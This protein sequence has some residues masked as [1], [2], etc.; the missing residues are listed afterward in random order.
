MRALLALALLVVLAAPARAQDGLVLNFRDAEIR[1]VIDLVARSTGQRFIFDSEIRGRVTIILEDEVSRDEALE[2]LNAA[3]LMVGYATLPGPD[4]SWKIQS[5]EAAKGAA[6]WLYGPASSESSRLVTTLVRLESADPT[7]LAQILG[8]DTRAAIVLP[9]PATNGLIIAASEDRLARMLDLVRALDQASATELAV[10]PLRYSEAQA[11]ADQL[12]VVFKAGDSPDVPWRVIVEERTN[13]LIVQ[14]ARERVDDVRAF[15]ALVDVPSRAPSGYH[16]VRIVNADAETVATH[17]QGLE[18]GAA[19][20]TGAAAAGQP[21]RAIDVVADVPT[22]SLI[23]RA[24]AGL[25]GEIAAVIAELDRI[26]PRVGIEAH[27]WEVTTARELE[28]GF[29][30]LIPLKVGDEPDDT[31]AFATIGDTSGL[32]GAPQTTPFLAR[33]TR[34]PL[35]IPVLGPD[36]ETID[37]IVPEGAA[38]LIASDGNVRMRTLTSPYL[39]AASGE[40]QSIFAGDQVPIPVTT[41]VGATAPDGTTTDPE[42]DNPFVTD[43]SIERQDV[44][45]ELRVK[46]LA[47]SGDIVTLELHISVTSVAPSVT[48]LG[49]NAAQSELQG[50]TIREFTVDANVRLTAGAVVVVA[51]APL[52]TTARGETGVPFF[53]DIPILGWFFKSTRDIERTRRLVAAVQVNMIHTAD[54]QRAE[55]I[56]RRLALE[57]HFARTNPLSDLI[58]APYAVLVATRSSSEGAERVVA[59]LRGL[60]G[61][62]VVV[63]WTVDGATQYDVYLAG[64]EEIS[65]LGPLTVTL[66]QLGFTTRLEVIGPPRT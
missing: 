16:V 4:G 41:G 40:E 30:A 52:D 39:L 55:S 37:A 19:Q 9:Y 1:D 12:E 33:F 25:F 62:P 11:L 32:L 22:N 44:G 51:S 65:E 57:R 20:A 42:D 6:P 47:V 14:A 59:D 18:F 35:V 7:E 3:L 23:I 34:R 24:P 28:L 27:V 5:V 49:D 10:F 2:V 8:Q 15:I 13:S 21:A 56:T 45:V 48:L 54:Q 64:F 31:F 46:P 53:K 36:G 43:L 58:G 66:R 26:P 60:S 17:L 63:P 61:V 29:N 38:E 50:P